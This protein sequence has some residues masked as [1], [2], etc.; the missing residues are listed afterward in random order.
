MGANGGRVEE[1]GKLV[2]ASFWGCGQIL[3]LTILKILGF[4]SE[5]EGVSAGEKNL[6]K[7]RVG[8]AVL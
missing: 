2:N 3:F 8:G 5:S 4:L 6:L 1:K 7:K